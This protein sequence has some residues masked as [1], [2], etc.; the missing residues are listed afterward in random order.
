MGS[1]FT[2]LGF[3]STSEST[4]SD[5]LQE[6]A[7]A[8]D[9]L[10]PGQARYLAGFAYVL[11]RL[12]AADHVVSTD[13]AQAMQR[14]VRE[15]GDLPADQAAMVVQLAT[16]QQRLF[17][18]TDDFLVTRELQRNSSYEQRLHLVECL[19]SLASTDERIAAEEADEIGRIARELRIEQVDLSRLRTRALR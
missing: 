8:L 6:I 17:G 4:D 18:A 11:S 7:D 10:D 13:E 1:I 19:F 16:H 12:A 14:L 9:R 5:G 15:K 3:S 2:F